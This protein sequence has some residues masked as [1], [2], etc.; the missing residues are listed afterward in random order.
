MTM[1]DNDVLVLD[2]LY[3]QLYELNHS[4]STAQ[5]VED[6][7]AHTVLLAKATVENV[8]LRGTV[9]VEVTIS[10]LASSYV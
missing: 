2:A 10:P 4:W 9:M 1:I 7:G 5:P 6:S 8:D 3:H